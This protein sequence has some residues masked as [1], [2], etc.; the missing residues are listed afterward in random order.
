MKTIEIIVCILLLT[1]GWF[2]HQ[3]FTD[4]V[5]ISETLV[6]DSLVVDTLYLPSKPDTIR[7]PAKT[8]TYTLADLIAN[9]DV[10]YEELNE[11]FAI[12]SPVTPIKKSERS[13]M[14]DDKAKFDVSYLHPPI[15]RFN[16]VYTAPERRE[17]IRTIHLTKT[18]VVNERIWYEYAIA[19]G[20]GVVG[21]EAVR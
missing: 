21:W 11:Q 10:T 19:F 13:F 14:F 2:L 6:R 9:G 20:I 8:K 15:D 1:A 7:V 4:P 16:V 3:T 5:I 17:I 12:L 18:V